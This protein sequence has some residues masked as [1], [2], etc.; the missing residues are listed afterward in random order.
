MPRSRGGPTSWE[1]CVAA[2]DDCNAR[3]ADKTPREAGMKLRS[4]PVRPAWRP[5]LRPPRVRRGRAGCRF[6]RRSSSSTGAL[7]VRLRAT[8]RSRHGGSA[9]SSAA[10]NKALVVQQTGHRCPKP[11]IVGANPTGSMTTTG[12]GAG[13]ARSL[14]VREVVG[15]IP[16]G[17]ISLVG[18]VQ[19]EERPPV[20]R[21]TRV[22]LPP[23]TPT[24]Y[25]HLPFDPA[26]RRREPP[27]IRARKRVQ[28]PR[29][30]SWIVNSARCRAPFRK[31]IGPSGSGVRVLRGPSATHNGV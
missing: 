27:L 4:T 20:K 14:G 18:V 12:R 16:T 29:R 22:Q 6:W 31:R 1:N 13:A 21:K 9:R 11:E 23:L 25:W 7:A 15:A 3:K 8:E 2:C 19:H 28:L 5:R 17:P 24:H 30:N 26:S 10:R